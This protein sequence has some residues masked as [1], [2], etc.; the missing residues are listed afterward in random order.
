MLLLSRNE[1]L[2]WKRFLPLAANANNPYSNRSFIDLSASTLDHSSS[3]PTEW[4]E[5]RGRRWLWGPWPET[6]WT[7]GRPRV[8]PINCGSY[9]TGLTQLRK[10]WSHHTFP[11]LLGESKTVVLISSLYTMHMYP[12]IFEIF[13]RAWSLSKKW[14]MIHIQHT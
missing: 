6:L 14:K 2:K 3:G 11:L 7:L 8:K 4:V 13:H 1:A 5:H 12:S 10:F 9:I